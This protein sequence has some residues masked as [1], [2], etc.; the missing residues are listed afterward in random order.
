MVRSG[1][2]VILQELEG[3]GLKAASLETGLSQLPG[4]TYNTH[5]V[6]IM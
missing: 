3:T 1:D 4:T 5:I 6:A 2:E